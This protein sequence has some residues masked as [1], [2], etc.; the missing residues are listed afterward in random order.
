MSLLVESDVG[1]NDRHVVAKVGSC[2][3]RRHFD[4]RAGEFL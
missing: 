3:A 2:F 4:N 1:S